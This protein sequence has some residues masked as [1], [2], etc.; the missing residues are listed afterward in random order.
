MK[1]TNAFGHTARALVDQNKTFRRTVFQ[2]DIIKQSG[3]IDANAGKA[4]AQIKNVGLA[5][6]VVE[7][8]KQ[9]QTLGGFSA[10]DTAGM[11]HFIDQI[12]TGIKEI[13]IAAV[14]NGD[15]KIPSIDVA[16]HTFQCKKAAIEE[17]TFT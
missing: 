13:E 6:A 14:F 5:T 4:V 9:M 16:L 11:G 12:F 7:T 1:S 3:R 17:Q 10:A 2:F 8:G 15:G